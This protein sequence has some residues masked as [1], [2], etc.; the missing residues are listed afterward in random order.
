MIDKAGELVDYIKE[1]VQTHGATPHT[2][3]YVREGESGPLKRIA[4]V[5]MFD[6]P[7]GRAII[8]ETSPLLVS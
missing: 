5:K 8:L 4:V 3:V 1:C 2:Y 6:D 7:R